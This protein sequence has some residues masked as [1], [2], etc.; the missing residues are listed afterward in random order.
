MRVSYY[1]YYR[2]A[3]AESARTRALVEAVQAALLLESGVQGKLLR[4]TDDA[5]TWME[6]YEFIEDTEWFESALG[7]LL[8]QH[9]FAACLAQDSRRHIERFTHM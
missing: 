5:S 6:I 8:D 7:R 1:I 4:R 2:V 3:P 9:G